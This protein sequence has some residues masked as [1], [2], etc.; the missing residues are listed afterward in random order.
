MKKV[1]LVVCAAMFALG[2][3]AQT[4]EKGEF[5]LRP[6]AG[7]TISSWN[8]KNIEGSFTLETNNKFGF[9][10]GVEFGYQALNW[11]QPSVGLFFQQ[12]GTSFSE[13][14]AD[15]ESTKFKAHANYLTVPVL[16]NF[17]VAPGLS[18]K[19]GIMPGFLMSAKAVVE[20]EE[21]SLKDDMKNFQIQIP[22]G[23]SY[24]FHNFVF[25]IR[26][27]IPVG[28]CVIDDIQDEYSN[29]TATISVGYNF[30]L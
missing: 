7:F 9:N 30:H 23:I 6:M 22:V 20:D 14:F 21:E 18:L 11:L 24:E 27:N 25:D 2:I 15:S 28:R 4:P 3:N 29:Y 13:T 8:Y 5:L 19:T 16:A 10:G 1:L 26:Y 17:Y 12:Q